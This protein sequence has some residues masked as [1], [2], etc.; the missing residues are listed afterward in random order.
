MNSMYK[1]SIIIPVFNGEKYIKNCYNAIDSQIEK[2]LEIIFVN[3]GSIDKSLDIL[4]EIKRN[5]DRVIIINQPNQ[6]VSEARNNGIKLT[7]SEY[8]GFVDVDDVILPDYFSTLYEK[9]QNNDIIISNILFERD[10][11][12]ILKESSFS[13]DKAFDGQ[14]INKF[15]LPRLLCIEDMTLMSCWNKLYRKDF[16][17]NNNI[18]FI[19][20]LSNQEDVV[21][22]CLA[23][24]LS[25]S[26]IFTDYAGY[27]YKDNEESVTRNF[28][29]NNIFEKILIKFHLDYRK[30]VD[31]SF[32]DKELYQFNSSLLM[33]SISFYIFKAINTKGI[34]LK[35]KRSYIKSILTNK[36]VISA[37]Q[38]LH[39]MYKSSMSKFE[40]IIVYLIKSNS[41]FKMDVLIISL[42][43]I[44]N[45]KVIYLLRKLNR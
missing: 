37:S 20:N 11:K 5:D 45:P 1:I 43:Y 21:F 23:F 25:R 9:I 15:I 35:V 27:I 32:T 30:Y 38:N 7:T 3:D 4:N 24:S 33:F 13:Y 42:N 12:L 29:T 28:I 39:P 18:F 41:E 31:L 8:I 17:L 44:L 34:T 26:I 2:S 6:G 36:D 22:N 14:Y 19:K 16:L 10:K 40:K